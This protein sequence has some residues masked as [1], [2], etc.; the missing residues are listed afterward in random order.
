MPELEQQGFMKDLERRGIT[1]VL[2]PEDDP[3]HM[4]GRG[5]EE[6]AAVEAD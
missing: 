2:V 6:P 5:R 3:D 4:A 1:P